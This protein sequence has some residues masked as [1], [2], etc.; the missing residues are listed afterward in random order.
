MPALDAPPGTPGAETGGPVYW[1]RK[2]DD[3]LTAGYTDRKLYR[4]Y[5][6]GE[7]NILQYASP[8]FLEVF[9]QMFSAFADNWMALVTDSVE[10]RLKVEGFRFGEDTTADQDAWRI[11]QANQLD[12][13]AGLVHVEALITGRGFVLVQPP[14]EDGG[15]P[16]VTVESSDQ[17]TVAVA[18]G[19]R[20]RR[21]A[22]L[23]R[24][25]DDDG[26][27][28]ATVYLP[29]G[30]FKLERRSFQALEA[31][32]FAFRDSQ[33]EW[34]PRASEGDGWAMPNPAGRCPVVPLV[35]NA[36]LPDNRPLG[37]GNSRQTSLLR[38]PRVPA[39]EGQSEL[40]GLLGIQDAASKLV[41]DM[42]TAAEFSAFRQR[43]ATGLE[44]TDDPE[45][46]KP[47]LPFRAGADSMYWN[48]NPE[49]KFGE[50]EQTDLKVFVA[51]IEMLVNHIA[52]Q[53]RT[54]PHYFAIG[55]QQ[56]PSGDAIRSAE[57]GLSQKCRKRT[58][59]FGESWEEAMRLAFLLSGDPEMQVKAEIEHSETVW[60]DVEVRTEAQHIDGL[61]KLASLK[62]PL[63]A[64]WER[65][66]FSPTEI[67]RF[68]ALR[69]QEA[70]EL[71]TIGQDLN[72]LFNA[73]LP[74]DQG[75]PGP[76]NGQ[77]PADTLQQ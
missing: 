65:A 40:K 60:R 25:T 69:R 45:T 5:Y 66:G 74:P 26:R 18:P 24:W 63:Q 29:D 1:A 72:S 46:G 56:W 16:L 61:L 48:E 27:E 22:A 10:E 11:W 47:R 28:L 55:G 6:D 13:D 12:G 71:G 51:G 17:V 38:R 8:R 53:S 36:K 7:H 52:S 57:A 58:V 14:D 2:L 59:W 42:M 32:G 68:Q 44:V 31:A 70:L 33:L 50:F 43:Y 35:N 15:L 49:A 21:L 3:K 20:R 76:S 9:G 37:S 23:K 4:D 67:E 54:P 41:V 64:L 30:V 19:S 75:Q 39:S 34:L 77:V 73:D 62:V